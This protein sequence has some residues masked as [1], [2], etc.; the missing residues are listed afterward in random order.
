MNHVTLEGRLIMPMRGNHGEDINDVLHGLQER[1]IAA[2]GGVTI[3]PAV[4]FWRNHEGTVQSE[5]IASFL[6]AAPDTVENN[7]VLRDIAYAYGKAAGQKE[8]YIKAFDGSVHFLPTELEAQSQ[9]A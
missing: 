5:D 2:F 7:A 4:G 8:V 6:I 1:L 9:A 3:I